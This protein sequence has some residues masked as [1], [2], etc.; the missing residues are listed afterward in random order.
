MMKIGDEI[1]KYR[2]EQS[3]WP[4]TQK[5]LLECGIIPEGES[6]ETLHGIPIV[7]NPGDPSISADCPHGKTD[8]HGVVL[9]SRY[10]HLYKK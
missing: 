8:A 7:Y 4:T 3:V 10:E 5:K 2:H 9:L 6:F 1:C